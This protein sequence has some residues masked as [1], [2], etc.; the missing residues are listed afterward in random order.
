MVEALKGQSGWLNLQRLTIDSFEQEDH[1]LFSA[2]T[3]SG[4]SLDQETC[5]RMFHC[6]ATYVPLDE[7]PESA[8]NRLLAE[9]KLHADAAVAGSLEG[10]Q[11]SFLGRKRT[12]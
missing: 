4:K 8:K 1:L 3:D 2:F 10:Q 7:V 9:T 11:P 6:S 12:A 5:E